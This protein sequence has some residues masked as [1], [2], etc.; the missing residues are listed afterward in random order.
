MS[1]ECVVLEDDII[2]IEKMSIDQFA[3]SV[4]YY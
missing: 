1:S 2:E 3:G 4:V